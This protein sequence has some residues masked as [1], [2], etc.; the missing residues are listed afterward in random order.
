MTQA[1]KKL[2]GKS[3][4]ADFLALGATKDH[5]QEIKSVLAAYE[6]ANA[7]IPRVA[8]FLSWLGQNADA[9]ADAFENDIR[10][11]AVKAKPKNKEEAYSLLGFWIGGR[12]IASRPEYQMTKNQKFPHIWQSD[13]TGSGPGLMEID[14]ERCT[15]GIEIDDAIVRGINLGM[16]E[17]SHGLMYINRMQ[18]QGG[19]SLRLSEMAVF[20][21]MSDYALPEKSGKAKWSGGIRNFQHTWEEAKANKRLLGKQPLQSPAYEAEYLSVFL[22]PWVKN[23]YGGRIDVFEFRTDGVEHSVGEAYYYLV[24]E[25]K[26]EEFAEYYFESGGIA[27]KELQT[28]LLGVFK[29]VAGGKPASLPDF[30]KKMTQAMDKE[31]GKPKEE[32]IPKG[33]VDVG[34]MRGKRANVLDFVPVKRS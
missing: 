6:A 33:F 20:Q 25:K 4:N 8:N 17:H 1:V 27:D 2:E 34:V 30:V 22:G 32:D 12:Y 24:K 14:L 28:C 7:N 16:H 19:W 21:C 13:S 5:L 3:A 31:F 26:P 9:L 29:D 15:R 11:G 23:F 18:P 10:T